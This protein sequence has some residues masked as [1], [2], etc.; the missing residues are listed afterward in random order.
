MAYRP[1]NRIWSPAALESSAVGLDDM[2]RHLRVDHD[3]E[4]GLI[5]DISK[6]ATE[7]VEKWTQRLLIRREAVLRLP[8]L[9]VGLDPIELPGGAV[10]AIVSVSAEGAPVTGAVVYGDSP[11]LLVPAADWPVVSA[12][13]FPVEI[14]YTVGFVTPPEDLKAA[15][16][17][18][19]T[20]LFE[21]RGQS[22]PG[23]RKVAAINAEWLMKRHRIAAI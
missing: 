16:K 7:A 10:G 5:E 23:D 21:T 1:R 14:T 22:A 2:K 13:G 12:E 6:A 8:G 17:L 11:A 19:A 9:P 3:A 20:D 18:I 4:D 15:V